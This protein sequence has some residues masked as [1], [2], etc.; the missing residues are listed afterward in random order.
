MRRSWSWICAPAFFHSVMSRSIQRS[1]TG[2]SPPAA[3]M[4][5]RVTA[6]VKGA[7]SRGCSVV[8]R[9]CQPPAVSIW[10]MRR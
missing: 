5:D 2:D 9:L 4:M 1:P 6:A 7:P 8:S 10:A 3:R